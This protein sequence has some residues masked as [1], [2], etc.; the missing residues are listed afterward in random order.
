MSQLQTQIGQPDKYNL[1][2]NP[3]EFEEAQKLLKQMELEQMNHMGNDYI[4]KSVSTAKNDF[5][6]IRKELRRI[7]NLKAA[8]KFKNKD[9]FEI[10]SLNFYPISQLLLNQSDPIQQEM[11]RIEQKQER[12]IRQNNRQLDNA[13]QVALACEDEANTIKINLAA[14][15]DKMQNS[16]LRN[17]MSIQGQTSIANRLLTTIK[18]ERLKNR[19]ILYLVFGV[20]ILAI[21]FILYNMIF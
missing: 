6:R 8:E 9:Q 16:V 17:L 3:Y 15:S 18:K 4:R 10:K 1:T 7:Q 12:M 11:E 20:I 2:N 21:I 13:K 19:I 5:D 14:Q